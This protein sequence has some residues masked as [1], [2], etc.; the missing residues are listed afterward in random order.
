MVS[1][2]STELNCREGKQHDTCLNL[3]SGK[4]PS[5]TMS[6]HVHC[7]DAYK[8]YIQTSARQTLCS[9]VLIGN[10]LS[11]GD[12]DVCERLGLLRSRCA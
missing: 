7:T 12:E 10:E 5:N 6:A 9:P 4:Y 1:A 2:Y 3:Y 11:V 8:T